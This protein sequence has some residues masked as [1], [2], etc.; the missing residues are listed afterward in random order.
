MMI[1]F[2]YAD[3]FLQKTSFNHSNNVLHI[4]FWL[5][6]T[7]IWPL[8]STFFIHI[9]NILFYH[10]NYFTTLWQFWLFLSHFD[11]FL[12]TQLFRMSTMF[13]NKPY[14]RS[15]YKVV[16][17]ASVQILF[18]SLL[19]FAIKSELMCG[20]L[21]LTSSCTTAKSRRLKLA[22]MQMIWNPSVTESTNV[23]QTVMT[24]SGRE[25]WR[26]MGTFSCVKTA[27]A[28]I[29][30]KNTTALNLLLTKISWK[31]VRTL[32]MMNFKYELRLKWYQNTKSND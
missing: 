24:G 22:K 19:K 3:H 30:V 23:T 28:G 14:S 29:T 13:M 5:F 21:G 4:D 12:T 2:H 18:C 10:D 26:P 11:H 8:W 6:L 7:I 20:G 15:I 9:L 31:L 27:F 32:F 16:K 1:K 17:L 25:T